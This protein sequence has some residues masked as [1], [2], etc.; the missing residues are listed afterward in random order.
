MMSAFL[1]Y[2]HGAVYTRTGTVDLVS[3]SLAFYIVLHPQ[4]IRKQITR[5]RYENDTV[6]T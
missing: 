6:C 5:E 3:F 4:E 1:G 2:H